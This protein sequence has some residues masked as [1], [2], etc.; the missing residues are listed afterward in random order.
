MNVVEFYLSELDYW[1]SRTERIK[2]TK[3]RSS[4][5]HYRRSTRNKKSKRVSNMV[6]NLDDSR[7]HKTSN[8]VL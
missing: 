3:R 5:R 7:N 6:L 1:R 4:A 2:E 8:L